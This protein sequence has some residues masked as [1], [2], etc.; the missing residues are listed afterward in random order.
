MPE[1]PIDS[2]SLAVRRAAFVDSEAALTILIKAAHALQA[3]GI[4]QW[5]DEESLERDVS[6]DVFHHDTY[7]AFLLPDHRRPVATIS[8]RHEP[9]E[10][11]QRFTQAGEPDAFYIHRFAVNPAHA[12]HGLGRQ[13]LDWI[14]A[15]TVKTHGDVL[16]RLD[17]WAGNIRLRR[18]YAEAGYKY[19][20][21]GLEG[22]WEVAFFERRLLPIWE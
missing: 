14:A 2:F 4:A 13:L 3:R 17:C 22:D 8:L 18:Y 5:T 16:L 11:W 10:A 6:V 1:S 12:G 20:G 21:E 9:S 19:L 7:L 15:E